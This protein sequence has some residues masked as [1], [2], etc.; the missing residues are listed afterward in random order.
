MS[1]II[2]WANLSLVK[3]GSVEAL[4]YWRTKYFTRILSTFFWSDLDYIWT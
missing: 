4:L 1:I 3:I 2:Y